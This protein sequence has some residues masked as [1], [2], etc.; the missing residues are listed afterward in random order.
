[1]STSTRTG[2]TG[3]NE[4]SHRPHG[5][6]MWARDRTGDT[7][8]ERLHRGHCVNFAKFLVD[9]NILAHSSW[10]PYSLFMRTLFI[11][12]EPLGKISIHQKFGEI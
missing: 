12:Q 5:C 11:S 4:H 9:R 7:G 3:V 8:V 2:V 1:M 10:S 6:M